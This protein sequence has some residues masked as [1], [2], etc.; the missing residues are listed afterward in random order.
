MCLTCWRS[1]EHRPPH[2]TMLRN[3]KVREARGMCKHNV[4]G[5]GKKKQRNVRQNRKE[6]LKAE[7]HLIQYSL[8]REMAAKDP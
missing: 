8:K 1:K 4:S 7:E 2:S 6:G 5:H 3:V